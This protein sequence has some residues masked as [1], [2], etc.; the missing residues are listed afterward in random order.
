MDGPSRQPY[1]CPACGKTPLFSWRWLGGTGA[2]EWAGRCRNRRCGV[3]V[4]AIV[5]ETGVRVQS[6]IAAA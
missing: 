1:P 4:I 3:R 5:S 6:V 2:Y